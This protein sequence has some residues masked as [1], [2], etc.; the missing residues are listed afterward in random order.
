MTS[1]KTPAVRSG[2]A[3][4]K[5]STEGVSLAANAQKTTSGYDPSAFDRERYGAAFSSIYKSKRRQITLRVHEDVILWFKAK[6]P[7]YQSYMAAVLRVEMLAE[8][9]METK[10]KKK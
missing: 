9:G 8:L 5:K 2:K 4:T 10:E 7:G 6:G 3:K 1:K